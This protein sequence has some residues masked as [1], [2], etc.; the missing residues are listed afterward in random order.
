MI[1]RTTRMYRWLMWNLA[2]R[3]YV[4]TWLK[5]S[6]RF[7]K[8][9]DSDPFPGPPFVLTANHANFFDPW[10]VGY[11][12]THPVAYMSADDAFRS[13]PITRWYLRSI[14][15]F[16]KKK[17]G[18]DFRAM[19]KTLGLL[20]S[21][22]PVC[23]FPEGQASWDGETQPLYRGVEKIV[24]RVGCPVVTINLRGN[25]LSN[26]YWMRRRRRG[27]I[28]MSIRTL[29]REYVAGNTPEKIF[30]TIR[31]HLRHDDI[32][33]PRNR[34]AAFRGGGLAEGL[35]R[36]VW[37]C[38]RC[39]AEDEMVC[40]G[41]EARCRGCG[42]V[43]R[44]DP[45]CGITTVSGADDGLGDLKDWTDRQKERV[46]E[47]IA[48]RS[49]G[50]AI[51]ATEPLRMETEDSRGVFVPAGVGKLSLSG[52]SLLFEPREPAGRPVEL[53]VEALDHYVI[54]RRD[55]FECSAGGILYRFV[56]D[57]QSPWKWLQYVR[58]LKGY[59]QIEKRG[60]Y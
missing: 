43:W 4:G 33:D 28:V 41:N 24:K 23:I 31:G 34:E 2:S 36:L 9:P 19:K 5:W 6:H 49:G 37:M 29:S 44:I 60:F 10:F 11:Y 53:P 32:K 25:Y 47:R 58:Y 59:E 12:S 40:E 54:Q 14:G 50:A 55:I 17:G 1:P 3:P 26:A 30:E 38:P 7:E 35:E 15:T 48:E 18:S 16:G 39:R 21:N 13:G 20:E 8:T 57:H 42:G 46:K 52:E 45:Y 51:T 27:R 22:Y 56:F